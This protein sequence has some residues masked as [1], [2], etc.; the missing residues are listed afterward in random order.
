MKQFF[1]ILFLELRFF[2]A[3][4]FKRIESLFFKILSL[5]FLSWAL[6]LYLWQTGHIS[7]DGMEFLVFTASV[8]G[9]K[10]YTKIKGGK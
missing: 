4:L 5:S 10:A 8:I 3:K 1:E 9:I 6:L 7:F 2:F